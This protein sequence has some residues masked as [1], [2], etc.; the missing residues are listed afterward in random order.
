MAAAG[1]NMSAP[2]PDVQSPIAVPFLYPNRE[3][4]FPA[5]MAAKKY[6]KKKASWMSEAC[7]YDRSKMIFKCGRRMSFRQVMNPIMNMSDAMVAKG[8]VYFSP[9][10]PLADADVVGIAVCAMFLLVIMSRVL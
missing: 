8:T 6:P 1:K 4:I 7:E 10:P 2:M 5:G 3:M 9:E